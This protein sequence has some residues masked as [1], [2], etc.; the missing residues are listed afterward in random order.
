MS[1][2]HRH[3]EDPQSSE[4]AI[5]V[6]ADEFA[7]LDVEGPIREARSVDC[8]T[9]GKLYRTAASEAE[10][11]GNRVA[12]RIFG[13]LSDISGIHF[14]PDDRAEPYGPQFVFDGRRSMI[15]SDLRGE[16]SGAIAEVVPTIRNPGLRARLADIVWN[17]HRNLAAMAQKAIKAYCEAVQLVLD[18]GAEFFDGESSVAALKPAGCCAEHARS[19]TRQGGRNPSHRDSV[20]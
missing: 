13:L 14:K 18:G 16:Q 8:W 15:P 20:H 6:T 2:E 19:L 9:L 11:S 4:P 12:V 17:N 7:S 1:G 10:K 5:R 3:P